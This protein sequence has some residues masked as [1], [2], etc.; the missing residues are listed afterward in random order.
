MPLSSSPCVVVIVIVAPSSS[1]HALHCYALSLHCRAVVVL[2]DLPPS[3]PSIVIT[4][5][6]P[7]S[8]CRVSSLWCHW[9]LSLHRL[10]IARPVNGA[11]HQVYRGPPTSPAR[12]DEQWESQLQD[13]L[14]ETHVTSALNSRPPSRM[15]QTYS[16][17]YQPMPIPVASVARSVRPSVASPALFTHTPPSSRPP[18][19]ASISPANVPLC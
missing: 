1:R 18:S 4:A 14:L 11:N 8:R 19:R 2:L 7:S 15:S 12:E 16:P 6:S 13:A 3:S 17:V 9:V 5:P 10:C